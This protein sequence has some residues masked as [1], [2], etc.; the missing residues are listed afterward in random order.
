MSLKVTNSVVVYVI[1][2]WFFSPIWFMESTLFSSVFWKDIWLLFRFRWWSQS[3]PNNGPSKTKIAWFL[4]VSVERK[5]MSHEDF[6]FLWFLVNE[7]L[8]WFSFGP[9]PRMRRFALKCCKR[10][11]FLRYALYAFTWCFFPWP[12]TITAYVKHFFFSRF[13]SQESHSISELFWNPHVK[14]VSVSGCAC[15]INMQVSSDLNCFHDSSSKV[16]IEVI[17]IIRYSIACLPIIN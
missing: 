15:L 7:I 10:K 3:G 14:W 9:C 8:H 17:K 5:K 16:P 6:R 11:S 1:Y 4:M 12:K 13:K 2:A